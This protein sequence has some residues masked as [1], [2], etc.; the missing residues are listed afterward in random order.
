M[1][2]DLPD[3]TD[4]EFPPIPEYVRQLADAAISAATH[5]G[6]HRVA[7]RYLAWLEHEVDA[8]RAILGYDKPHIM[9]DGRALYFMPVDRDVNRLRTAEPDPLPRAVGVLAL[10]GLLETV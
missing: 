7:R 2:A 3:T 8:T 10:V 4:G 9:R 6:S 5:P 1:T